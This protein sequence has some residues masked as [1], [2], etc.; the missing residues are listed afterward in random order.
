MKKNRILL[1]GRPDSMSLTRDILGISSELRGKYTISMAY[2]ATE[3]LD[4]IDAGKYDMFIFGQSIPSGGS[5]ISTGEKLAEKVFSKEP[6]ATVVIF[7]AIPEM[8][9]KNFK[10]VLISK[11]DGKF[12]ERLLD[13][14]KAALL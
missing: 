9:S 6:G 8:V 13:T 7:T 14:V 11:T 2:T 4:M 5:T 3:A 1:V 10:G 12:I